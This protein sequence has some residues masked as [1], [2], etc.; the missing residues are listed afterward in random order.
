MDAIDKHHACNSDVTKETREAHFDI[1]W[2]RGDAFRPGRKIKRYGL[3]FAVTRI[4]S[5][6]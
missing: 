5:A 6:G 4:E 1:R 3:E 2:L